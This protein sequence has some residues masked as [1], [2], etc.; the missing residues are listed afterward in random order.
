MRHIEATRRPYESVT[1]NFKCLNPNIDLLISLLLD[2]YNVDEY[3]YFYFRCKNDL[4][5]YLS[6]TK[7]KKKIEIILDLFSQLYS[8][9]FIY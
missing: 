8:N 3:N 9:K 6:N 1:K 4:I 7:N 2:F 5:T